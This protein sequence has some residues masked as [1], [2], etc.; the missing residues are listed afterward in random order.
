MGL[1]GRSGTGQGRRKSPDRPDAVAVSEAVKF[2][3]SGRPPSPRRDPICGR[4]AL[5]KKLKTTESKVREVE[6]G[7]KRRRVLRLKCHNQVEFP[8]TTRRG[9]GV[10]RPTKGSYIYQ[11][12]PDAVYHPHLCTTPT[13][14]LSGAQKK[15]KKRTPSCRRQ[16]E[17]DDGP[18]P[19]WG[20]WSREGETARVGSEEPVSHQVSIILFTGSSRPV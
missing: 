9:H 6:E 5:Q 19:N 12:P 17:E 7:L 2:S 10:G 3:P 15:E 8:F 4:T 14:E 11:L 13:I 20:N 16:T 18:N 1:S